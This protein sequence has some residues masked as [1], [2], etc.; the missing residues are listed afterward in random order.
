MTPASKLYNIDRSADFFTSY[1]NVA[2]R[3]MGKK[4]MVLINSWN[5]FQLGTS[6]EPSIEYGTTY[7]DLTKSQFKVKP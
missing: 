5:N 4:R 7:L 1:A 2:K 3:N 6:L